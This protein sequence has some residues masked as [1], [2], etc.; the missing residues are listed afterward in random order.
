MLCRRHHLAVVVLRDREA[1][2]PDQGLDEIHIKDPPVRVTPPPPKTLESFVLSVQKEH[3]ETVKKKKKK[4]VNWSKNERKEMKLG[5][6]C[7]KR[8]KEIEDESRLARIEP[9]ENEIRI[10]TYRR[11]LR[12][13]RLSR[14][15]A[16][17]CTI[18]ACLIRLL[19]FRVV[20][21]K[22]MTTICMISHCLLIGLLPQF[23]K[24]FREIRGREA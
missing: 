2:H 12:W 7:G 9:R 11:K 22:M 1:D 21:V 16:M 20:S 5:D 19:E 23:T 18:N 6:F 13:G 4:P 10:E 8:T 3:T 24:M 14:Q 15:L 17:Q